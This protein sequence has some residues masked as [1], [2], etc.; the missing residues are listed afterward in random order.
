MAALALIRRAC[1]HT[2]D[3]AVDIVLNAVQELGQVRRSVS[4][5]DPAAWE[6][7][8]SRFYPGWRWVGYLTTMSALV[9]LGQARAVAILLRMLPL[10]Q[11][12]TIAREAVSVLLDLVFNDGRI[13]HKSTAS[14]PCQPGLEMRRKTQYWEP[15]PQPLREAS[16][17][18]DMQRTVL[19]AI[20]VHD[21]VWEEEHDL[22]KLYGL[23]I[24][25]QELRQFIA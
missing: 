17:L 15:E 16:S 25:R 1:E 7:I 13:Q 22:L 19:A 6:A 20:A 4:Q 9:Q 14:I 21:A 24:S 8:E 2:P 12:S 10:L 18:T 23:P 11:D 3:S 5:E